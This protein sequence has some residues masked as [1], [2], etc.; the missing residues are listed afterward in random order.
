MFKK[1][2]KKMEK[3]KEKTKELAKERL[4]SATSSIDSFLQEAKD[5]KGVKII[6]KEIENANMGTL[7]SLSDR[8]KSK[9]KSAFIFLESSDKGRINMVLTATKNLIQKGF[10]AGGVIKE[11]AK[12]V[13]GSG[14]GRSDFAQAGGKNPA[15][16]SKV[17]EF[18]EKTASNIIQGA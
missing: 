13:D 9:T 2:L 11:A 18:I 5:I 16:L 12:I 1:K 17:F 7:R 6:I 3:E 10:D 8:I 4:E 15:E 14:G